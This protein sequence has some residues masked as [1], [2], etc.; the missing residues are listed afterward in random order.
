[1]DSK[2]ADLVRQT[3]DIYQSEMGPKYDA[4]RAQ[5]AGRIAAESVFYEH[6][7]ALA[8]AEMI[9]S[10]IYQLPAMSGIGQFTV[11]DEAT[12]R[13]LQSSLVWLHEP[14]IAYSVFNPYFIIGEDIVSQGDNSGVLLL[15]EPKKLSPE[16]PTESE[17]GQEKEVKVD[18]EKHPL[19]KALTL[20]LE[21]VLTITENHPIR[22]STE[23][24][25]EV[26]RNSLTTDGSG[27]VI[28][29]QTE[30]NL[31]IDVLSYNGGGRKSRKIKDRI[32][33]P[34][35]TFKN[36]YKMTRTQILASKE[37]TDRITFGDYN[38]IQYLQKLALT[39][40]VVDAFDEIFAERQKK[41]TTH[42]EEL[43]FA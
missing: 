19:V 37:M 20:P 15:V 40:G 42:P 43:D 4:L 29:S 30:G 5:V 32:Y 21:D 33:S 28:D 31:G 9:G 22:Q 23:T 38:V 25:K 12:F 1:M 7:Q 13:G 6:E 16:N 2:S 17:S 35:I 8:N 14:T 11:N 3:L 10:L 26:L 36:P 27:F 39:F 18:R 24:M 34:Y 41:A